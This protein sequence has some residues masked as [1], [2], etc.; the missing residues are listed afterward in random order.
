L[1]TTQREAFL[2]AIG[3]WAVETRSDAGPLLLFLLTVL[4]HPEGD[5]PM[6]IHT[7]HHPHEVVSMDGLAARIEQLIEQVGLGEDFLITALVHATEEHLARLAEG[8]DEALASFRA[9]RQRMDGILADP[10]ARAAF[11]AEHGLG[12]PDLPAMRQQVDEELRR[13]ED[14][15]WTQIQRERLQA[16]RRAARGLLRPERRAAWER[17]RFELAAKKLDLFFKGPEG[18]VTQP[19]P[20]DP[21]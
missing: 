17:E 19:L 18:A 1:P 6:D 8:R 21:E 11:V 13:L 15:A 7:A 12:E 2:R 14:P 4:G 20:R 10:A 3:R 5:R 16:W 9:L